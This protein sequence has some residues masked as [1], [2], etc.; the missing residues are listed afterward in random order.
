MN[1]LAM[2]AATVTAIGVIGG[3]T[4]TLNEMHVS[5]DDF[6][7]YV[8][9]Q[10]ESDE[11]DYVRDLKRDI[12]DIEGALQEDPDEQ[13]LIEALAELID[14]LCEYRPDDRL[15]EDGR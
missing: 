5:A 9:Q 15:C 2:G 8:Q 6:E 13:Y 4:L 12:R 11:R 7:K 14:E 10:L 1:P 3:G